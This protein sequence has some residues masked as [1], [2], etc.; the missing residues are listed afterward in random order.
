MVNNYI[1]MSGFILA[2]AGWT[3]E[4]R[5]QDVIWRPSG[6]PADLQPPAHLVELAAPSATIGRAI[7]VPP[8]SPG[9]DSSVVQA[10]YGAPTPVPRGGA[11]D[12]GDAGS[13]FAA[14]RAAS[15]RPAFYTGEPIAVTPQPAVAPA[16]AAPPSNVV[17]PPPTPT[18]DPNS[19][20][21]APTPVPDVDAANPQTAQVL[22]PDLAPQ[23]SM[24]YVRGEY[25]LWAFK[26]DVTPP[27]VTTSAPADNGIL[28]NPT[29]R[30]LFGGDL[31][32]GAHS[33]GRF[34]AGLWLDDCQ[35]KAIEVSGFFLPG[36]TQQF[37]ASSA[38]FA[39]L[40]RPFFSENRNAEFAQ[41]TVFPGE[42]TGNIAVRNSS[43]LWGLEANLRCPLW[44]GCP[45][46]NPCDPCGTDWNYHID[47]LAGFRYL[48][49]SEDLSI[50]EN[51]MNLPTAP[52]G[53]GNLTALVFDDFATRNQF[54]GAQ[55]GLDADFDRGPWSLDVTGKLALGD[56]NQRITING[57][58][59]VTNTA[60]G[61]TTPFVGGLL[62]LPS[63]IGTHNRNE[64]SVVPEINLTLSYHI[65]EH[66]R[67]FAGYDFLYW[68]N[69]VRPGQQ[70]DCVLDETQI[71][72][73]DA[74]GT[75][76]P[77]GQNR[78]AVLFHESDFWAQGLNLGLEFRY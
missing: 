55:V 15:T 25:L 28:G 56:T 23:T 32:S 41:L 2:L 37:N 30:V 77:V 4:A 61:V 16:A 44:C 68:T 59:L 24:L 45:T 14:D 53:R 39:V 35:T 42:S 49:L 72:N 63:N 62:A 33:G 6:R 1:W 10:G 26:K 22:F 74:P 67:V 5:A 38:N 73:F 17:I 13:V 19:I 36:S 51:V 50:S 57:G 76:A 46:C 43:N 70:I 31:G 27:L 12:D 54:Y 29:T 52:A 3:A 34:T 11:G 7:P 65:N 66:W 75:I 60:T 47:G 58:Q 78:P 9:F 71:P 8:A 21:P 64:F 18:A 20:F 40:A 69:V 48:N